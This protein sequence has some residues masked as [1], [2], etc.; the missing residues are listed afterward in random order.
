M[1]NFWILVLIMCVSMVLKDF[2]GVF[3]VIAEA[4][5]NAKL[6]AI[7]NPLGTIAGIA[8]YSFGAAELIHKYHWK[9]VLGII[10]VLFVDAIDGYY[11]TK[12]G[13][14]IKS[15]EITREENDPDAK[16]SRSKHLGLNW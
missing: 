11:F 4:R 15:D 5:G 12:W 10:P 1:N 7:L 9:G 8:F 13:R 3:M 2:V 6:T 14:K 16:H